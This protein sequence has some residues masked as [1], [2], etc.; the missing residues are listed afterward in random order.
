MNFQHL[1]AFSLGEGSPLPISDKIAEQWAAALDPSDFPVSPGALRRFAQP[2]EPVVDAIRRRIVETMG[3]VSTGT[4]A[5]CEASIVLRE[6]RA[7]PIPEKIRDL[8]QNLR[9]TW[10]R[11]DGEE[12]VEAPMVDL[13]ARTLAC[14]FYYRWRFP[15]KPSLELVEEWFAARKA[16]NRE[17]REKLKFPRE[18]MDSEELVTN[19]ARRFHAGYRGDLPTWASE[20]WPRWE[21]VKDKV[22]HESEAVWVDDYLV[23]DAVA[24]AQA[25]CGVVWYEY[26]AFGQAVAEA[27]KIPL[28]TGGKKAAEEVVLEKGDRS[29]VVSRPSHGVGRDRLQFAFSEQ[30]V[31]N[32]PSDGGIWE[33][34]LG[35]LHRQGQEADEVRADVYRHCPEFR[36]SVDRALVLA[37]FVDGITGANQKLL[38]ASV[39][40][41]LRP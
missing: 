31:A 26:T 10:T 12:L 11:P 35:R 16:W 21:E 27:G 18:H 22:P 24:W 30:L 28:Y 34:L 2:D 3:V 41:D 20:H 1:L 17:L 23:H 5:S 36:E 8:I 7:P 25:N 29:V 38:A 40:W 14:G 39:E 37:K 13:A 32:P 19:A 4:T 15:G 6:R 33:Q 9:A